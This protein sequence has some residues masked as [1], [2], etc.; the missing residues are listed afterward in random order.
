MNEYWESSDEPCRSSSSRRRPG[1]PKGTTALLLRWR[2]GAAY[3]G[4]PLFF[5]SSLIRAVALS[6]AYM[7]G[8]RGSTLEN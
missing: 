1:H 4:V 3:Q 2:A 7:R 5:G 8:E 6:F